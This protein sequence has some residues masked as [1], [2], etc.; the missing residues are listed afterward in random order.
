MIKIAIADDHPLTLEGVKKVLS[1]EMDTLITGEAND[2]KSVFEMLSKD[3]P[4]ILILDFTMPG[5]SG[6]DML[7]DLKNIYPGLPILI[8][9]IHP[10]E[11]Y[12][13]RCM[14]SGAD[15]YLCKSSI[16]DELNKAVRQIVTE[17]RKYIC[18]VLGE[19]L[20]TLVYGKNCSIHEMLSDREFEILCMIAEG[21]N[22]QQIAGKLSLSPNTIH[23]YR[24]R[25]M[26][27]LQVSSDVEMAK[28]ALQN[29]LV[30]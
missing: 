23:T 28:Y 4:D 8:L 26:D 14:K 5:K 13:V 7:K 6:L 25:I 11:R 24:Y 9:S 17:K 10:P 22:V 12:A 29:G 30:T 19:Q 15:G 21:M 2:G 3:L 20:A 18:P 27:K 16:S 1:R